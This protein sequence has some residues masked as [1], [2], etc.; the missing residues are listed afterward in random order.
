MNQMCWDRDRDGEEAA[1]GGANAALLRFRPQGRPRLLC[2][3]PLTHCHLLW[4]SREARGARRW[5]LAAA[6]PGSC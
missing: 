4:G 3:L 2:S 6:A 1:K 5:G